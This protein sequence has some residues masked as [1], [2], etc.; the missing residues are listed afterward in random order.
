VALP[1]LFGRIVEIPDEAHAKLIIAE[2]GEMDKL[3]SPF[4]SGGANVRLYQE[5]PTHWLIAYFASGSPDPSRN[6]YRLIALS[7]ASFDLDAAHAYALTH[8]LGQ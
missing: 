7:K 8:V 3:G 2:I 1:Q 4:D 5:H 6:G